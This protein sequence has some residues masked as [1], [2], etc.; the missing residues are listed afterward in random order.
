VER[1]KDFL[2]HPTLWGFFFIINSIG[3]T[4]VLGCICNENNK[5]EEM[6]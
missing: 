6:E 4:E 5:K 1:E 3:I 2:V